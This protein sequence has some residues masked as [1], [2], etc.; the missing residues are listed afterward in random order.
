MFV[1]QRVS[2]ILSQIV[3]AK[4]LSPNYF[5]TWTR[6]AQQA[7]I[8]WSSKCAA[9]LSILITLCCDPVGLFQSSAMRLSSVIGSRPYCF[10]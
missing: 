6:A 8:Y 2:L 9:A 3:V 4:L 5:E 1:Y 10:L 7:H